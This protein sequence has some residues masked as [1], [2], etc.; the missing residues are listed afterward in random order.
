MNKELV[1]HVMHTGKTALFRTVKFIEDSKEEE[2]VTRE[3]VPFL[4]VKL[5]MP[6]DEFVQQ[7]KGVVYDSIKAG[8]TDVQSNGKKRVQGTSNICK[9]VTDFGNYKLFM[10]LIL[11]FYVFYAELY[12]SLR[13]PGNEGE[14]LPTCDEILKIL[15]YSV[16]HFEKPEN[17]KDKRILLWYQDRYLPIAVGLEYWD[18]KNRHYDLPTDTVKMRDGVDR[19]LVTVSSKSFGL[20]VYDNCRDKWEA[21][22][23]LKAGNKGKY[24]IVLCKILLQ[25]VYLTHFLCKLQEPEF[26][27]QDLM[28]RSMKPSGLLPR[29]ARRNTED[30]R[31]KH[32]IDSTNFWIKWQ[33]YARSIRKMTRPSRNIVV[34]LCE[35]STKFQKTR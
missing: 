28:L 29:K 31:I 5:E 2:E 10:L 1:N 18:D 23:K 33:N 20:M 15:Q 19:T 9:I 7:Y 32:T 24:K 34:K 8:R 27:V 4:P 25:L 17:A 30:G 11:D 13:V 26:H 16:E 3:I 22:M 6:I 21:I 14:V 35:I 12:D